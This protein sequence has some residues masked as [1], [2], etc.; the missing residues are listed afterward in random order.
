[1]N[2][3]LKTVILQTA[4]LLL[5]CLKAADYFSYPPSVDNPNHLCNKVSELLDQQAFNACGSV[6]MIVKSMIIIMWADYY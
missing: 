5:K 2:T 4:A 1:M 6:V 3:T